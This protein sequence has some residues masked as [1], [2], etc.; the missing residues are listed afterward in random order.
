MANVIVVSETPQR[1]I[2]RDEAATRTVKVVAQGPQGPSGN[3][4]P[5]MFQLLDQATSAATS[6]SADAAAAQSSSASAFASANAAGAS[7]ASVSAS[8]L[9]AEGSAVQAAASASQASASAASVAAS[10]TSAANSATSAQASADAAINKANIA[11]AAAASATGS[12]ATATTKATEAATSATNAASSATS[13]STSATTATTK[14]TQ[15]STS[16]TLAQDWAIKT[17]DPVSGAE[18]SSKYHAQAASASAGSASSSANAAAASATTAGTK[19]GEASASAASALDSEDVASVAAQFAANAQSA[20]QTS[21]NAA[22]ASKNAAAT[23]ATSASNSATAASNSATAAAG[24]ATSAGNSATGASSSAVTAAGSAATATTKASE[25]STSATN[26]AASA[27]AAATSATN[28]ATSAASALQAKNDAVAALASKLDVAATQF[29]GNAATATKLL[30]AR[31]ISV[32]GDLSWSTSFDGSGNVTAS[33]TLANSGVTAGTYGSATQVQ[34]FTVDA[35][36]RLTSVGAAVT[37]TPAWG[38]ITGKPTTLT[39]YG[40]TDALQLGSNAG[41]AL[42]M[43]A[44]GTATTAARSDHV[45]PVQTTITGNAGSATVLQTARTI[46]GV[47][48]NGSANIT[49]PATTSVIV[50]DLRTMDPVNVP[51]SKASFYFTSKEGLDTDTEGNTYGDFLALS[52]YNDLSGGGLNGLLFLK[53]TQAIYHYWGAFGAAAWGT[54]KKLAYTDSSITGNAASATALATGRTI[55]MTGDVSWTSAAFDGSAN[56]TGTATLA[57]SGVAAGTYKSVTVDAK[58]RVTTGSN[59]TT[60][61]G[62]GITDAAPKN[63]PALTGVPTAPTATAGA[64]TTQI[65]TTAFVTSAVA[66]TA[67]GRLLNVRVFTSANSGSTYTPTAGTTS[68]IVEAVGAG[69]GGGGAVATGTNQHAYGTGGDCGK[70]GKGYYKSGFSGVTLTIGAGGTGVVGGTG[71]NGGQTS[72]GELLI[73]P[74][75][76]GGGTISALVANGQITMYGTIVSNVAITGANIM[77]H[78]GF[79]GPSGWSNGIF[80]FTS[81][82]GNSSFLGAGGLGAILNNNGSP[83]LGYGGGGSGAASDQNNGQRPGGAGGNG[84]IVVYEYA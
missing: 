53:S 51:T 29:G 74:G 78:H 60:L 35:K 58:G 72:F 32:T 2:I 24:S 54:P 14:A 17:V 42:G 47:S 64:N 63:S 31:T 8:E 56:V 45:H 13:A 37:I 81:G 18:Y 4:N 28:A 57:N 69:G 25:A 77:S 83:A 65:A 15:A 3:V 82:G 26:A 36:G 75:G 16:S 39:G 61:S 67:V 50:Q 46:N 34:P 48:F 20:A 62:Y 38:S 10:V 6:A 23:S 11:D 52:T 9:A 84:L 66:E 55:G 79:Q 49:T 40:I 30:T 21:A 7:A 12:A 41:S 80:N 68:V 73:C 22:L 19:A 5:L 27:T 70:Y 1:V 44:A 76:R 59:P 33:G 43:A 71:T